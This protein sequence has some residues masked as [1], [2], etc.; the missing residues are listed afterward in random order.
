MKLEM[1]QKEITSL[2]V[3]LM[4]AFLVS[5]YSIDAAW[6]AGLSIYIF[7][8]FVQRGPNNSWDIDSPYP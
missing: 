7:F 5:F 3:T 2:I 6:I 1:T 8:T 4:V